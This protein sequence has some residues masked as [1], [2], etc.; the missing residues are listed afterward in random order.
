MR[1]HLYILLLISLSII[2]CEKDDFCVDPITPNLII[3]FYDANDQTA[4]KTIS[5]LYVWP[6]GR[7]SVVVNAVTDSI[8]IPLDVASGQTIYN[9]SNG[10]T[11]D[12][13]TIDYT[14][15]EIFVSR[16]C[17]FKAIFNNVTFTPVITTWI[18]S[19]S[20]TTVTTIENE[21]AAHVQIFH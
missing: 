11:Q 16:S 17:G 7:D 2:G 1:K 14:T 13:I 9:F 6:E 20:P 8:A 4:L 21:S 12:Q 5:N 18:S 10:T 15:Q 19:I 3:R